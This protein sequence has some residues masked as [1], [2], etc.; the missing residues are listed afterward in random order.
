MGQKVPLKAWL[1]AK[2][3]GAPTRMSYTPILRVWEFKH[4]QNS[5]Q[6]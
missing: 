4:S 2:S 3:R 5:L 6:N 1:R